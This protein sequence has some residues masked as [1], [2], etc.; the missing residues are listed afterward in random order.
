MRA[1]RNNGIYDK[2]TIQVIV[3][4]LLLLDINEKDCMS[5]EAYLK[6]MLRPE[7]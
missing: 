2:V 4:L 5:K 1:L 3:G 6:F 7:I